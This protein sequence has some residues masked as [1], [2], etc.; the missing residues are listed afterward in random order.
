MNGGHER[1]IRWVQVIMLGSEEN[2]K[3]VCFVFLV[4]GYLDSTF[5][6]INDHCI[7]F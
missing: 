5:S 4:E 6:H 7:T 1:Q 2:T 3:D